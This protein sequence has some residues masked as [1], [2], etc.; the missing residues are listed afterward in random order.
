M[1]SVVCTEHRLLLRN[2]NADPRLTNSVAG[3]RTRPNSR[4]DLRIAEH[5]KTLKLNGHSRLDFLSRP[6]HTWASL[7]KAGIGADEQT[8]LRIETH[9]KQWG[10]YL[11][12]GIKPS[13][14]QQAGRQVQSLRLQLLW[15]HRQSA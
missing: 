12:P 1:I 15:P 2:E 3:R 13:S 6:A 5:L 10:L 8:S 14:G 9:V 4:C 11:P 7:A